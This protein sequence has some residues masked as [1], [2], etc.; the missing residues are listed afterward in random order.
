MFL[1]NIPQKLF[2]AFKIQGFFDG[3]LPK[4]LEQRIVGVI[5]SGIKQLLGSVVLQPYWYSLAF[6][7]AQDLKGAGG[8]P[9]ESGAPGDLNSA[10]QVEIEIFI[11][12]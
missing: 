7:C 11:V 6:L 9:S 10:M 1:S 12:Y 2:T 4:L 5:N 8:H 3:E